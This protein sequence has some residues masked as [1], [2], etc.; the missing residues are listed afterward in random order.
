MT[1][2]R[3]APHVAG[4]EVGVIGLA[5]DR[6]RVEKQFGAHQRHR[7]RAFGIPLV[8]THTDADAGAK[9]VPDLE[10]RV[11]WAEIIFL[12]IARPIGDVAFAIGAHDRAIGA[13]HCER[14][15]IMRPI[16]LEEAGRDR[17]FELRGERLHRLDAGMVG[18]RVGASE[19]RLF[20]DLAEIGAFKQ[21]GW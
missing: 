9:D 4:V 18:G 8:P 16:L 19:Q 13:D 14:V 11:A 20:F 17:N 12:F 15:V 21:F 10:P 2:H 6:G 3:A 1:L 7:T 5:A